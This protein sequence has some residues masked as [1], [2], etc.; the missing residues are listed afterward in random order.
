M[1]R[2]LAIVATVWVA[3]SVTAQ[4]AREEIRENRFLAGSNYLDYDRQL[5][6]KA[7][8]PAPKGYVPYYMSH[9]GRHGSRWLISKDSYTCVLEPLQKAKAE[10]KLSAKGSEVLSQLE[11]FVSQPA[12]N[13][14]ALDGQWQGAQPRLGDLTTVGERQ[15]HGIGRRMALHFPELF[16]IKNLPIDARSTTVNRCILSMVAECEELM[17]AN[18]TARIHNDVS[19]ALQYYLNQP[20][21]GLVKSQGKQGREIRR[22][23]KARISPDRLMQVLFNDPQWTRDNIKDGRLM[24][25]LFDIATNMQSHDN[26]PDLYPLFTDDEVYDQWRLRNAGWYLDYGAAPQTGGVMPFSQRNLLRNIIETADT[27]TRPQAT[28]RFGHEVCVMPLACLLEL[29]SCGASISDLDRVDDVWR[30]YRIFPMACNIQ[31]VFYRPKKGQGDILVK[32]LLNERECSLPVHTTQYPYYKWSELRQYYLDKLADYDRREAAE[33]PAD[34]TARQY[35]KYYQQLP[36]NVGQVTRPDIPSRS[37][38]LK[39]CGGV[40]DGVTLNTEA[41]RKAISQLSAQGGGRLDVPEGIWLTGPIRLESNIELHLDKNAII[42]FSPDKRLYIDNGRL[43]GRVLPCISAE[44]KHDMAITGSGIIDGN[45]QQWRPVKRMKVSDVE[46]NQYK[47]MGGVERQKGSLWYPWEMKSGYPDIVDSPEKQ[48]KM[49]NDL[50]R[51]T[52][53]QNLLFEGVTFQNAPKFHVHPLYCENIIVDGITVRCPWNAQNGDAIDLSDCHRALIVNATVDAGDDGICLKSGHPRKGSISGVEDVVIQD[54]TVYHAHG[55]FV[56]GSETAAG[57]RRVVVRHN[58]FAGTDT[59]LRFKSGLGRG[60]RTEQLYI[61]DCMMTDIKDQ[62]IIF[63]C[64]YVDRPA[65]S[66]EKAVPTFTEEQLRWKP[67]FQDIHITGITCR[68]A[69]TAIQAAGI[70]GLQCVHDIDISN[71]TFIYNKVG[72]LIDEETAQL[73]LTDVKLLK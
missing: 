40:G 37:L 72:S 48:E 21:S 44:H 14:P 61:S 2:L 64:D 10:G 32:A 73:K 43:R 42:Y 19:D 65:G 5:P 70:R 22:T 13:F 6:T 52:D 45:G 53:C 46:W 18:P 67:D 51:L 50:V 9:Y 56:L 17:A 20:W 63:Q 59:G 30:N 11:T 62:A 58:R 38:N 24:Y 16:K 36:V 55:G 68:G 66:D 54:N 69:G 29:D 60:G 4:T 71:S 15:H 49:R 27:V 31:L 28:L 39:D 34:E 3:L 57:V 12:P 8:T 47:Q 25:D 41:F 35:A 1:K 26:A 7:L 33:Q 23:L